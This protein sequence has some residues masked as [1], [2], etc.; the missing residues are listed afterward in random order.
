[1]A[2]ASGGLTFTD[3]VVKKQRAAIMEFIKHIGMNLLEIKDIIRTSLPVKIFEPKSYLERAVAGF[4]WAPALLKKAAETS[5]P[6]ERLKLVIAFFFGGLHLVC[7][8]MKPFNPILGETFQA[9]FD[10]ETHIF[11]EQTSHHPPVTAWEVIGPGYHFSGRGPWVASVR[12]N[13]VKGHQQGSPVV[14]FADGTHIEFGPMP[15]VWMRGIL[16]GE[17]VFEYFGTCKF[18]YPAHHLRIDVQINPDAGMM[19]WLRGKSTPSDTVR[20]EIY[21][22]LPSSNDKEVLSKL[23]GSWLGSIEFDGKRYWSID[24][25]SEPQR[26]FPK[27]AV[28]SVTLPS[29]ARYREDL[30]HL[31]SGDIEAATKWK[32]ELEERQR[33]DAKL[34]KTKGKK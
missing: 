2:S 24:E 11:C 21:R 28:E 18:V 16:F 34:R 5:D 23:E 20:G 30:I 10:D 13:S 3:E 6:V 19:K 12:G 29:D 1:M 9:S 8:Q 22:Q 4:C 33:Y 15:E 27:K 25:M 7:E 17:R 26:I 31:A 14:R 32:H